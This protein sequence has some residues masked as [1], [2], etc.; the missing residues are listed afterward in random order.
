MRDLPGLVQP[1]L[2][3]CRQAGQAICDHYHA[4][5]AD[6]YQ[7]KGD[8][9]PLTRA[10]IESHHI[11]VDGLAAMTPELPVLSEESSEADKA[12][13]S[14]WP[15]FWLVDPLDGTRE[16][17]ART[18]EFT[19][20]IALVDDHAPVLGVIYLPLAGEA[21]VG[22]P[23]QFARKYVAPDWHAVE[24][25]ARPLEDGN[26]MTILASR[27]HRGPRLQSSLDW[28]EQEWGDL[29]R[30]NSGS[31]LKFCQ[32]AAGEGDFYPRYSP[33]CEWDT[34]AGQ[35]LLEAA[36]GALLGLDGEPLRYNQ[37][38]TL[39]SPHFLA[40]ADPGHAIWQQLLAREAD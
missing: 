11:L 30:D 35:A 10:D 4:P 31:A 34:A 40:I 32:L 13:R 16:F 7:A 21:Y 3:L 25:A 20:N 33:C 5:G 22:I 9:S 2:A 24:L 39:L 1:L 23:G 17:L 15:V 19:I 14:D 12:R 18:G 27:R 28:L 29:E 26:A 37:R 6:E 38:D 8:E 36:G